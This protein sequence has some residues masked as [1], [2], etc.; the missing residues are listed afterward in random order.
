MDNK[1]ALPE[2]ESAKWPVNII[3]AGAETKHDKEGG[4]GG[5]TI[6]TNKFYLT[7]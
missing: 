4:Y 6:P 5:A 3:C 2:L 1:H 7:L